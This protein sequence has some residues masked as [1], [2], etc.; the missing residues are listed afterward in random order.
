[1]TA[2]LGRETSS[3]PIEHAILPPG[4]LPLAARLERYKQ[5]ISAGQKIKELIPGGVDS[6]FRAF[7]EVGGEAIFFDSASGSKRSDTTL[8]IRYCEPRY[9][10]G[11]IRPWSIG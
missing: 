4:A 7:H 10:R 8:V 2:K 5:S 9:R 1:M 11:F 3:T 6:P